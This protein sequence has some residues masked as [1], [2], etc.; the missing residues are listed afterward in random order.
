MRAHQGLDAP[1]GLIGSGW[2]QERIFQ[3][4]KACRNAWERCE[5]GCVEDAIR[6]QGGN[7]G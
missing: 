3:M 6:T 7:V 4:G 1:V 2:N 5:V